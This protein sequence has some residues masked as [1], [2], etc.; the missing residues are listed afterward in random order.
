[1]NYLYS[2]KNRNENSSDDFVECSEPSIVEEFLAENS[3]EL[4]LDQIGRASCREGV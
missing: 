1:M 3:T 2:P 4:K